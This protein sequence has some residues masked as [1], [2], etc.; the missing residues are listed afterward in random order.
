MHRLA[1]GA[2][3]RRWLE[4]CSKGNQVSHN[5]LGVCSSKPDYPSECGV[6]SRAATAREKARPWDTEMT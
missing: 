5:C 1:P 4:D 3:Q 6:G 2:G